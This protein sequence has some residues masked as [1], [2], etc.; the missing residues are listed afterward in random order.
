MA[1]PSDAGAS[2]PCALDDLIDYGTRRARAALQ[3]IGAKSGALPFSVADA[4]GYCIDFLRRKLV[5]AASSSTQVAKPRRPR[6]RRR[7]LI[8]NAR[9]TASAARACGESCG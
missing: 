8:R 3:R 2:T 9:T 6:R 7:R 4:S 1:T 5:V